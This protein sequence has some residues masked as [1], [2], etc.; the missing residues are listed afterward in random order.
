MVVSI[1]ALADEVLRSKLEL[2]AREGDAQLLTVS[3]AIGG[4]DALD[5]ARSAGLDS[6]VYTGRKPPGAWKDTPADQM[7]DLA[8][9][10]VAT[11]IFEGTAA[12]AARLYPKNANVTAAVAIA[13]VGFD[14]TQVRLMADPSVTQN[15]HELEVRG[16]FGRF[17]I[18][19]ENNPLPDNPKTS[20]L[21]ALSIE[22]E[23][24][25]YLR[26][27]FKDYQGLTSSS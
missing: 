11:T 6:V 22:A 8:G 25:N 19:L 17:I 12:D 18:R 10:Q 9:L 27:P 3:G 14:K 20:W 2:A 23:L 7:F 4:L 16:A 5:A 24:R 26:L 13:G 21:A 1:G 15:V